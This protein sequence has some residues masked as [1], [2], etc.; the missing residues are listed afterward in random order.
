MSAIVSKIE[1][2]LSS[3]VKGEPWGTGPYNFMRRLF[4]I[5]EKKGANF[6]EAYLEPLFYNA[7]NVNRGEQGYDPALHC[8]IPF[9][10]GGL[11]EP[12]D[13]YEWEHNNFA[14]PNEMFSNKTK[15]N[16]RL[17]DGICY[18]GR[19]VFFLSLQV[20]SGCAQGTESH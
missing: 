13:G 9:L 4:E 6:F 18:C 19:A 8:R 11:F 2:I 3:C 10:S 14:I 12:L 17:A 16:D 5:S 20:T 15:G 1:S 7:L